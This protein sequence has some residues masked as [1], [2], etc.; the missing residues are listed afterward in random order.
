MIGHVRGAFTLIGVA[1]AGLLL[2]IATLFS[3]GAPHWSRR[4]GKKRAFV[5]A[6]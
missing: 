4:T 1:G 2:W 3:D 5:D 6:W